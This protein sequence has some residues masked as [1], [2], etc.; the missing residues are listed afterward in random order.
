[1]ISAVGRPLAE[2]PPEP[3]HE[4]ITLGHTPRPAHPARRLAARLGATLGN[5]RRPCQAPAL[6]KETQD[7]DQC[8]GTAG[9][10]THRADQAGARSGRL[11]LSPRRRL[12]LPGPVR[13]VGDRLPEDGQAGQETRHVA[14]AARHRLVL[15]Q[16]LQA[17]RSPIRNL[18]Q[19]RQRRPRERHL[20]FLLPGPRL[21]A[22]ES[23]QGAAE[24]QE[25]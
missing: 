3:P 21:R 11:L 1:M 6:G 17:G 20:A 9:Q 10:G 23:P 15:C 2:C 13:Q 5:G 16:G 24:V 8:L 25:G 12:L 18:R 19:L 14:L 22:Q 4:T 7:D